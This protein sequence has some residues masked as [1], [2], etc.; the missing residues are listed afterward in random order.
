[1]LLDHGDGVE[2]AWY[3][4]GSI[5]VR[6]TCDR[7]GKRGVIICAPRLVLNEPNGHT[8]VS[9]EHEPLTVSPSCGCSDCGLHGFIRNGRWE[10][11]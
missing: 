10:P 8:I 5:G 9:G 6:H 1:M 7:G 3:P 2:T 4:D 11:C